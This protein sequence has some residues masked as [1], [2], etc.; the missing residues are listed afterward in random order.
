METTTN[1]YK[2]NKFIQSEK[3][4]TLGEFVKMGRLKPGQN[5][6]IG[7]VETRL[8]KECHYNTESIWIGDATVYHEPSAN[9]GGFGWNFNNP[10]MNKFVLEI[11]LY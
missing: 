3:C 4:C 2:N 9:D 1:T 6:F 5:L 11:N 10:V 8:G 7:F